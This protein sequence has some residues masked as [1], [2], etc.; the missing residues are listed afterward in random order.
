MNST[1]I[2]PG[3]ESSVTVN[4]MNPSNILV[5]AGPLHLGYAGNDKFGVARVSSDSGQTWRIGNASFNH[6]ISVAG[7][8]W[9]D[10]DQVGTFSSNGDA[11]VGTLDRLDGSNNPIMSYLFKST[12]GGNSFQ[13]TSPFLRMND[14]LLYYQNGTMVHPCNQGTPPYRDY[15]AVI[16]DQYPNSQYHDNVYIW[17][18]MAAQVNPTSCQ[19]G[20]AF[21]RS[22]DGGQTWGSGMWF[23][24]GGYGQCCLAD[25]RGMAVAPDGTVLLAGVGNGN[26]QFVLKS[27]DGGASFQE[28]CLKPSMT[29]GA[30]RA[31]VAASSASIFYVLLYGNN[32][33]QYDHLY[34]VVT[35]D[36]GNSWSA[37]ARIDDI[38]YPD[39]QH[40]ANQ[41]NIM[42][43]FSLSTQTGR[44]DV[45]WL[46]WRNNPVGS[47]GNW[48]LA[49]I[50]YGYSFDGLS[51][52]TNIR[53][54]QGPYYYC[55]GSIPTNC[56]SAG[57]D[58]MWVTSSG[59]SAY[60]VASMGATPCGNSCTD[61]RLYTRF[62]TVTPG[63]FGVSS[64]IAMVARGTIGTGGTYSSVAVVS[65]HSSGNFSGMVTL[66]PGPVSGG[67]TG[68]CPGSN[69]PTVSLSKTSLSVSPGG[70][71]SAILTVVSTT[72]TSCS[73]PDTSPGVTRY[74]VTVTATSGSTTHQY[75]VL[76]YIYGQADIDKNG[77]VNILDVAA[78][79]IL[80][81]S[82]S[83][84]PDF[85]PNRDLNNDGRIDILDVALVAFYF[86]N[87]GC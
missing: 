55:T 87:D 54:T 74:S 2:G 67:P 43:D 57:N 23:W 41:Y 51:W 12:D 64:S 52:A 6:M 58:F 8:N 59:S 63:D 48:T 24:D 73:N 4:P 86:G 21:Q 30:L 79:A 81:G 25:N 16:A 45:A 22:T 50:Y 11:Y 80:F 46:D 35:R 82:D 76:I 39:G 42:W 27:T 71:D 68:T 72:S 38:T 32:G 85:D 37:P 65:V 40:V 31:E 47:P 1:V 3:Y 28:T 15:P 36:G 20:I 83:S 60:I 29:G 62:V 14:S 18:R 84:Q 77:M 70:T 17:D 13:L 5:T 66:L 7:G 26:C 53:A 78:V 9:E 69:C 75:I 61:I 34:S 10:Y 49:D 33:T 44:L 19:F 56:N